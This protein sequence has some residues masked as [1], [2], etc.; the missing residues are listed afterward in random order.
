LRFTRDYEIRF[1]P[2]E[3]VGH[4][5]V[6]TPAILPHGGVHLPLPPLARLLVVPMLAQIRKDPRLL[7][8]LLESL[9][10]AF[11]ILVVVNDDFRQK[12]VPGEQ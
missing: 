5:S 11:E 10:R 8:L 9:Q 2:R 1:E 4:L 12:L 3:Q 6:P 7:A